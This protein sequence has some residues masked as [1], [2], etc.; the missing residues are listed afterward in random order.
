M[1]AAPPFAQAT[2]I[3]GG[4]LTMAAGEAARHRRQRPHDA[5]DQSSQAHGRD[6][7]MLKSKA[8]RRSQ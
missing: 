6:D 1:Q 2:W 4:V 8:A 5:Q 7:R 3:S